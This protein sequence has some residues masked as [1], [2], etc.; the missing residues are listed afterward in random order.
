VTPLARYDRVNV[1]GDVTLTGADL[2]LSL[3]GTPAFPSDTLLFILV[4][5]GA[6]PVGGTFATLNGSSFNAN[7]I[8]LGG[9]QFQ[10]LYN[11]SFTGT[12]SYGGVAD[13]FGN[14]VALL[15]VVPE[16]STLV[17]LLGGTW[18]LPRVRAEAGDAPSVVLNAVP[19]PDPADA[20]QK[21]NALATRTQVQARDVFDLHH[22]SQYAA[23]GPRTAA[24]ERA[25]A[26]QRP[27][28]LHRPREPYHEGRQRR[29]L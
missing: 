21:I 8:T 2:K 4:N 22:L 29:S 23:A 28:Q 27:I 16:P 1:T 9:P 10:L 20:R 18:R 13:G 24:A 7:N 12:G 17:T 15:F 5:N 14:D 26:A 19:E 6:S 25:A 3:N 11:A